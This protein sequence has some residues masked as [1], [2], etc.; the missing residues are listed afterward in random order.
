MIKRLFCNV[1]MR[2]SLKEK[3]KV[4]GLIRQEKD[5]LPGALMDGGRLHQEW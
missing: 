1:G 2:V 4:W 3:M 5:I